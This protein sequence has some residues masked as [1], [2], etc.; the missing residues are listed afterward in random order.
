LQKSSLFS[1]E[2]GK[3]DISKNL[4]IVSGAFQGL[5]DIIKTRIKKRA[6]GFIEKKSKKEEKNILHQVKKEDLINYGFLPEFIGRFSAIAV[7]NPLTKKEMIE[8]ISKTNNNIVSQTKDILE[9]SDIESDIPKDLIES[10]AEDAVNSGMGARAAREILE[11]WTID[12][13]YEES[14]KTFKRE[15]DTHVK[16]V[17]KEAF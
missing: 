4:F 13:I 3:F 16:K 6:I 11:K 5:E 8:I 12:K 15:K 1:R 10:I 17:N 9:T 14:Q 7:M 2:A